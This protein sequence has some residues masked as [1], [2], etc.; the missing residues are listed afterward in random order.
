MRKS[1]KLRIRVFN[2]ERDFEDV[3]KLNRIICPDESKTYF[4]KEMQNFKGKVFVGEIDGKVAGFVSLG[5]PYFNKVAMT[6][7]ICVDE[8]YQNRGYGTLLLKHSI[9]F[10]GKIGLRFLTIRTAL[11][12][13]R[14]IKFYN[15][16]GFKSVN[17][18]PDYYGDGNDMVWLEKD[19]RTRKF[20][21][22]N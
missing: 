20:K 6:F 11:W 5:Y 13:Y 7:G 2:Y 15:K 18:F 3:Y 17:I 19:L 8:K 4:R 12:N 21:N 16:L 22:I 1:K 14:G 10:A 9:K